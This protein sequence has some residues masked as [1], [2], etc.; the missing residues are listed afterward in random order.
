MLVLPVL[1][2]LTVILVLGG[3][4]A[5]YAAVGNLDIFQHHFTITVK[6]VDIQLKQISSLN[7]HSGE[8][9]KA[10]YLVENYSTEDWYVVIN[11][12]APQ[13]ALIG[14]T[15]TQT[16]EQY[17]PGTKFQ[18]AAQSKRE[19]EISV[20]TSLNSELELPIRVEV[21]LVRTVYI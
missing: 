5:V 19:I 15:W 21:F 4:T 16:G 17:I 20:Q 2:A 10:V 18:I 12:Y 13:S 9:V 6:P 7:I 11:V 8:T 1:I 3:T 14:A